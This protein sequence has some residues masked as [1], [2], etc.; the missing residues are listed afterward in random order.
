MTG[1]SRRT[2]GSHYETVAEQC[3]KKQG[4]KILERNFYCRQGEIDLIARDGE[5]LVFVEVK[6]R[7]SLNQGE[8]M[9]AVNDRKQ[10]RIAR[11]ASY[12]LWKKGISPDT[13]CR[14]DVVELLPG[15]YR[16]CEDAFEI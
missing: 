3:L 12:Y 7:K 6:Y 15:K 1:Q 5:V 11:A 16:I 2:V 13:P 9:E 10:R 4:Y 14:F 8:P